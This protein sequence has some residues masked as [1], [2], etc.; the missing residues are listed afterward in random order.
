M[1]CIPE[2][3]LRVITDRNWAEPEIS[4]AV[5]PQLLER[6]QNQ[7]KVVNDNKLANKQKMEVHVFMSVIHAVNDV[8]AMRRWILYQLSHKGSLK[9]LQWVVDLPNPGIELG[10]PTFQA[11]SLLSEPLGA[12][13]NFFK[14][15]DAKGE[16][17]R[18]QFSL[19]AV[20]VIPLPQNGEGARSVCSHAFNALVCNFC[21]RGNWK[22]VKFIYS[23]CD[24]PKIIEEIFQ[25]IAVHAT[26]TSILNLDRIL[27]SA[28][29][30]PDC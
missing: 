8:D 25:D 26:D 23:I 9:T 27:A 1:D 13:V 3:S 4:K 24:F 10:S 5:Y 15:C 29:K 17:N 7:H 22:V 14:E 28:L 16:G 20:G 30:L 2:T 18:L 11:D 6:N 19:R 12:L 21:L